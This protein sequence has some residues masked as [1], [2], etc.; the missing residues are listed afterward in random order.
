MGLCNPGCNND[1]TNW[2]REQLRV[3]NATLSGF[4]VSIPFHVYKIPIVKGYQVIDP[5]GNEVEVQFTRGPVKTIIINSN[6]SL[7]NH[8]LILY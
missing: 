3:Y 7:N 6:I 1:P 2:L 5:F 4:S 8:H